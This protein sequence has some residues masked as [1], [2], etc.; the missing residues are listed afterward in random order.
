[1]IAAFRD[2]FPD[3][4]AECSSV[5]GS[6]FFGRSFDGVIAWG[7][8]F[9]LPADV[10]TLVMRKVASVLNRGGK[11]LFTAPQG[12]ANARCISKFWAPKA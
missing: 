12:A 3:A 5:E 4:H 7:L 1:M 10:Q 9:L 11:F 8:M 6:A 2:R